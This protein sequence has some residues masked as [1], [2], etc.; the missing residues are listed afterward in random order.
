MSQR[1]GFLKVV[2]CFCIGIMVVSSASVPALADRGPLDTS[3]GARGIVT[4]AIG[5]SRAFANAV[6][7]QSDRKIV[8]AGVS[9]NG[10]KW[11]F[12]VVRYNRN[13]TLD[14]TFGTRGKV[15]TDFVNSP[16]SG[17]DAVAIQ[18]DGK[19][20]VVG[21]VCFGDCLTFE[22]AVVRY[23][24][25]GSLDATFGVSGRVVISFRNGDLNGAE[26]VA[27][28][29]DGKI[30]I[31]GYSAVA[32]VNV[33]GSLDS[34]FGTN[35]LV[36]LEGEASSVAIQSDGKIVIAG[37]FIASTVARFNVDGSLDSSFGTNGLVDLEG[38]ARSV[39]IQSDGKIVVAGTARPRIFLARI[40]NDGSPDS[41]FG[42]DGTVTTTIGSS[43]DAADSVAIETDGKIVVG[44]STYNKNLSKSKFAVVRYNRNGS[45]DTSFGTTGKVTTSPGS[46]FNSVNAIAI[47]TDGKHIVVGQSQFGGNW[48][49]AVV[50]YRTDR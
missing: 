31:A 16:E 18:R 37:G 13:G 26:A 32:R 49:F 19:I 17:A 29:S 44:G 15:A 1:K 27:I 41:A 48:R 25:N 10:S 50:R 3:F 4:T 8:V 12:S 42:S 45:L 30:V 33:D 38:E 7:I 46:G 36:D 2:V 40:N 23:N 39:A 28:Q 35:G 5:S 11:R 34:S 47:Q 21:N 20:V 14:N 24:R 9:N 43:L 22:M 6:A